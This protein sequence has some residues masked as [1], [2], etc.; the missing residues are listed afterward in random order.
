MGATVR[1]LEIMLTTLQ[2][3]VM[4]P[5]NIIPFEQKILAT[6]T[7]KSTLMRMLLSKTET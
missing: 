4:K 1:T 3:A 2:L 7:P 6:L 5:M